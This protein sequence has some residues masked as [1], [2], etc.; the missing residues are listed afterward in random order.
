MRTEF[1]LLTHGR[2]HV[3][4]PSVQSSH[5]AANNLVLDL[6]GFEDLVES[7][8]ISNGEVFVSFDN[9]GA[10]P[11][12]LLCCDGQA[13][14]QM[15]TCGDGAC[16]IHACLGSYDT[17]AG[18]IRHKEPRRMLSNNL[19]RDLHELR[20]RV[21]PVQQDLIDFTIS[22]LWTDAIVP[23]VESSGTV[24]PSAPNEE[25]AFLQR[26][27]QPSNEPLWNDV[28]D[29]IKSN[30]SRSAARDKALQL[31]NRH[32]RDVFTE[33]LDKH[34]WRP[35]AINKGL[36]PHEALAAAS[37][38]R[39]AQ[40]HSEAASF[41]HLQSPFETR[42]ELIVVRGSGHVFDAGDGAVPLTKYDALFD[43]RAM[44]D[45][46]RFSFLLAVCGSGCV[47][48]HDFLGA[49]VDNIPQQSVSTLFDFVDTCQEAL[50]PCIS[51]REP[52]SSFA[53][54]AWP[55]L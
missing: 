29:Q 51:F 54:G 44:F 14:R 35:M 17:T 23:Y 5:G 46:I 8:T 52:P 28:L 27:L 7:I 3:G 41:E 53:S 15:E 37:L 50:N 48:L 22:S 26:L 21:R 32:S 2:T 45:G 30:A 55:P 25:R 12:R 38:E 1:S 43:A 13:F 47:E 39:I 33:D 10:V 31:C 19:P 20:R 34:L 9:A 40:T 16:A 42:G 11:A 18:D 24:K 36:L 49:S 6:R 4:T